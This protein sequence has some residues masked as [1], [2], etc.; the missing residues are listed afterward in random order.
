M[1]LYDTLDLYSGSAAGPASEVLKQVT[2]PIVTEARCNKAFQRRRITGNM[3]CAGGEADQDACQGD[4]GGPLVCT[5]SVTDRYGAG[6]SSSSSRNIRSRAAFRNRIGGGGQRWC[7]AG[8]TSFGDGC[9]KPG[10]P[11]VYTR[12]SSYITW[13]NS[14]IG[15]LSIVFTI[16]LKIFQLG[17]LLTM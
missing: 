6:S 4:S 10:M 8:V 12:I 7:L 14:Q 13:I 5:Q 3:I 2:L 1:K 16:E 11:G 17:V 9:G 15:R